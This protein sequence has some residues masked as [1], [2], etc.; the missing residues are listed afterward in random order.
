MENDASFDD[1]ED[2]EIISK[3]QLKRESQ[4]ITKL[5][6]RLVEL[7]AAQVAELPIDEPVR[8]AIALAHKIQNKR[9]ALKR[10]YL[11]LGKLLRARDTG[12]IFAA[13]ERFDN[14]SQIAIQRH[15]TAERWRD[16]ILEQGFDAIER[17]IEAQPHAD[18]QHLRQLW[19]NHNGART[20]AK[21]IQ[22]SRLIYK[23][24]KQTLDSS[25]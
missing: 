19:R 18:R 2:I 23:D 4:E 8:E 13:V 5:G 21:K 22:H 16:E 17:F 6:K 12:A 25:T 9:A 7:S 11:F 3:S 24:I 20:D 1:E 14:A 10:H 15:H